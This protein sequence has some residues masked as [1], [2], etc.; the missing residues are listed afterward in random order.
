MGAKAKKR[1]FCTLRQFQ[2]KCCFE[3]K[4]DQK[5]LT[6]QHFTMNKQSDT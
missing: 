1:E 6:S 2:H 5:H 4:F 3:I